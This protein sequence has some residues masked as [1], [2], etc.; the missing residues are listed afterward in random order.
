MQYISEIKYRILITVL[1][2][3]DMYWSLTIG[4]ILS[5]LAYGDDQYL[6]A[7]PQG[8]SS[9]KARNG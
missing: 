7:V 9:G 8:R 5:R 4:Q 6:L 2:S 1:S 3:A